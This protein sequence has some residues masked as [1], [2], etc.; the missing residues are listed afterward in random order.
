[1]NQDR[2][3]KRFVCTLLIVGCIAGLMSCSRTHAQD[4][5]HRDIE[6]AKTGDRSLLLDLYLPSVQAEYPRPVVI[7]IHGGA[8]RSGSKSSVPVKH[9]IDRGMAIASVDYRLSGEAPFPAQIHDIKAAI[10]FLR[11]QAKRYDLDPRRFIVA[12]SSAGGH[13]AALVGVTNGVRELEGNVGDRLTFSSD[14]C[15]AISFFGASNLQTILS[16][17]TDHGLSVR[18]PALQ[19]LLGGQPPEKRELARL[20]SPVAHVDASDPPLWLIHGDADPQMP[21]EQSVELANAYQTHSLRVQFDVIKGGKHGGKEFYTDARLDDLADQVFKTLELQSEPPGTK[22]RVYHIGNSLTRNVPLERLAILFDSI[23]GRY[24]YGTQLGGGLRLSQHLVKRGHSGPP[25][26]GKFNVIKQYGQYDQALKEFDFDALIL[27]PYM[28]KLD[29]P[30]KTLSRWPFF[31]AGSL[32]AAGAFMDFAM[33]RTSPSGDR[34]DQQHANTDHVSTRRFYVY[35]TWPRAEAIL[36]Q[37]GEKTYANYWEAEYTDDVHPSRDYFDRLVAGL[38]QRYPELPVPVR[39]IPAGEVLCRLDRKIR[40]GNLPGIAGFFRR[41]QP[42]YV[43]A[44][45]EKAPF[46]PATFQPEQGVLNLYADGVHMNDQPHNGRDSGTIG[47]YVAALTIYAT[48]TGRNPVGLTAEPYEMFD[49]KQD[50]E[51]IKAL[52]QTVWDV[53]STHPQTGIRNRR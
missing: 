34:W 21:M 11:S 53:V 42:Y 17:S 5:T 18:V 33:G 9:W 22:L 12:G 43:K 15:A 7:W 8:W 41:V 51:L 31:E 24:D 20:A 44:R 32:Q 29:Q 6:Y 40:E 19:L 14:V 25:D 35:A 48:L 26:S 36:E 30:F 3:R 27:Q 23:G 16:Q 1:M 10:R 46:N 2:C 4:P 50:A 39:V 47:S 37:E 38:N 28:E 52:Q 45:G 49:T 13:L